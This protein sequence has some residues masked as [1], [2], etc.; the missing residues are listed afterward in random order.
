MLTNIYEVKA[1]PEC[2]GANL[3][4]LNE[5]DQVVCRD[6]GL[7]YE[8]LTPKE[9]RR[10]ERVSQSMK[11]SKTAPKSKSTKSKPKSKSKPQQSKP[12]KKA[13]QKRPAQKSKKR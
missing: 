5:R 3:S 2:S 8:P 12:A 7:V 9:E 4:Y 13:I 11:K 1:C 6:C 10:L